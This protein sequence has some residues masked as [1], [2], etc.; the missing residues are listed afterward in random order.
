MI[1]SRNEWTQ[2]VVVA[3][4]LA[5]ISGRAVTNMNREAAPRPVIGSVVWGWATDWS[6]R[7][8]LT[9]GPSQSF[10]GAFHSAAD[11]GESEDSI[12]NDRLGCSPGSCH[13]VVLEEC[14]LDSWVLPRRKVRR[15]DL[16]VV[17]TI[18]DPL[19]RPQDP[20]SCS[21]LDARACYDC[22]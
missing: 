18:G 16:S 2:W 19:R 1:D 21:Q 13:A 20:T 4:W 15:L 12:V 3:V 9:E 5:S 7:S 10:C 11:P 8:A 22:Y 14:R 6:S 17:L